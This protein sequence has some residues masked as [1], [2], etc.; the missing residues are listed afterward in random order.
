MLK[1]GV[2]ST[3]EWQGAVLVPRYRWNQWRT[4]SMLT[5]IHH[6][7]MYTNPLTSNVFHWAGTFWYRY[8]A[9][10]IEI[11]RVLRLKTSQRNKE[12]GFL[13]DMKINSR[14]KPFNYLFLTR[15]KWPPR[16]CTLIFRLKGYSKNIEG[17]IRMHWI[18]SRYGG[19]GLVLRKRW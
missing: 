11:D 13:H 19:S 8:Q 16:R 10:F 9:R 1:L 2:P 12:K 7:W 5:A 3:S 4:G 14:E 6:Q 15:I 18:S 17:R